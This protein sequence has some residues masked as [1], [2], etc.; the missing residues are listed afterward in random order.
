MCGR[1][2]AAAFRKGGW[3]Y[4]R[5]AGCGLVFQ[6]PLPDAGTIRAHYQQK[7][8]SGNYQLL[9]QF[10]AQYRRIYEDYADRLAELVDLRAGPRVLDVGCFT[11]DFLQVLRQRGA[12]V[13]GVELQAEAVAV[14][15][16]QLPGRV[17]A[18]T[19][20][21]RDFPQLAYDVITLLAVIEHV[22]DPAAMVDRCCQL[23]APGGVLMIETP[24]SGA[25]LARALG[26]RWPPYAPVEHLHLFSAQAL[27]SL[28]AQRGFTSIETRAHVKRL[29]V[30]YVYQMTRS[31]GAEW[32]WLLTPLYRLLP[33][34]WRRAALPFYVG[35]MIL[36]ARQ[37]R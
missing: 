37:P 34:P 26:K 29:P 27:Q 5:C 19:L 4:R 25:L 8:V 23:L 30:E 21:S 36:T 10:A 6:H 13:Y 28:L 31:F 24:N 9:A 20:E 3:S 33:G 1:P 11:G 15:N 7:Y 2:S 22:P 12:D 32:R 18:A 14:A 35:E 16:R 17:F